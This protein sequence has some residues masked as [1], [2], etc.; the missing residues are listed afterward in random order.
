MNAEFST[1]LLPEMST[2]TTATPIQASSSLLPTLKSSKPPSLA[3]FH[4]LPAPEQKM[5]AIYVTVLTRPGSMPKLNVGSGTNAASGCTART[6]HYHDKTNRHLPRFVRQAYDNGYTLSHIGMLCWAP[7]PQAAMVPRARLFF[8]CLEAL[9][10]CL[11]YTS[12]ASVLDVLWTHLMPWTR[13]SISWEPLNSHSPLKEGVGASL[14]FSPEQLESIV[15]R[16]KL[17]MAKISKAAEER[18]RTEDLE[19]YRLRKRTDKAVWV[20]NNK[21][22]SAAI[23]ARVVAKIKSERKHFCPICNTVLASAFALVQHNATDHH[24][25]QVAIANGAPVIPPSIDALRSRS[26]QAKAKAS[27][28]FGCEICQLATVC[29]A[30]LE[31]HKKTKGHI[32]KAALLASN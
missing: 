24:K 28:R 4:A 7:L 2:I 32:K 15:A 12:F 26:F 22:R 13:D 20:A 6:V 23:H 14:N 27:K 31:T 10:T 30:K 9:F 18:E 16:R 25:T 21:E 1:I 3:F 17:A 29:N 8:L 5:W 11:F 19:G